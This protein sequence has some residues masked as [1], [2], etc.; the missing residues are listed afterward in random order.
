MAMMANIDHEFYICCILLNEK[1]YPLLNILLIQ[2][3]V[4]KSFIH[5]RMIEVLPNLVCGFLETARQVRV[6][7]IFK[8][9]YE[10]QMER[11]HDSPSRHRIYL[12][13]AGKQTLASNTNQDLAPREL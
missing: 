8:L 9:F 7:I 1:L 13:A 2:L 6:C 3:V 12:L 10:L 11:F 4:E 5:L